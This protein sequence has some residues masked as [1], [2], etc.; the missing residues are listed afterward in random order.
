M[1][2]ANMVKELR[3][4]TGAGM[5][6][7]KK[8]LTE[9]NGNMEEAITWLREKGISKAAKKQTRIAA[10]GLAKAKVEGNKAVIVEVNSETDFVAKNPEFTGLVDLIATAILS[11]NVKTVEEVMKLEV[12][13]NTI[14][15]IITMVLLLADF[16]LFTFSFFKLLTL[17]L[18]Y[19]TIY[20]IC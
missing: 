20:K 14:E 3:E 11:S 9:T 16:F 8:A 4:A 6:D 13:G 12:E 15:N 7:C 18:L 2:T 5:L 17:Y 10:E 19:Y 1:I